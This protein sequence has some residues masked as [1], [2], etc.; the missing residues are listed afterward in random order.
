MKPRP[1]DPQDIYQQFEVSVIEGTCVS[2]GSFTARSVAPDG[3]PPYF[4]GRKG[5]KLSTADPAGDFKL[6]EAFG[7]DPSLRDRLPEFNFPL[8]C[9]RSEPVVVGKWYC[10][11]MFVREGELKDRVRRSVYYEMT[12][13]QKW[14]QIFAYENE[15]ENDSKDENN[16]NT[17]AVDVVVEG[18]V[19]AVAEGGA[20]LEEGNGDGG[21]MWFRGGSGGRVGLRKEIVERMKWEQERAGW[22]GEKGRE[23][24]VERAE[25][26]GG[27][28]RWRR[29]GCYV[30][31]ETFVLKRLDG[32]LVLSYGFK[33]TTHQIKSRW[34]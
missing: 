10:P 31:V 9:K 11:F 26:Y 7:L 5:W 27:K 15:N 22:D 34:E 16:N 6:G 13:E 21:V 2:H 32:S 24:R 12:L 14:E 4:L 28:G 33:H 20:V 23:V 18:E 8:H 17:V 30:L 3:L 19:I 25:E 29:F 1:L